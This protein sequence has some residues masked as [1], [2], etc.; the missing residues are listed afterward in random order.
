MIEFLIGLFIGAN[1]GFLLFAL[2]MGAR[3]TTKEENI[4][5]KEKENKNE[6]T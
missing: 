3:T 4:Y 1:L 5:Y 6:S 2:I